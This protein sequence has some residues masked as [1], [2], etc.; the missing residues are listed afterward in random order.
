M[1]ERTATFYIPYRPVYDD[2]NQ[3]VVLDYFEA[4]RALNVNMPQV[5]TC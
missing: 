4:D 1:V 2:S 5:G 3:N